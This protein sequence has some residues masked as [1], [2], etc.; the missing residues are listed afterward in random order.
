MRAHGAL[1][2]KALRGRPNLPSRWF[3]LAA[4]V[5]FGTGPRTIA[6]AQRPDIRLVRPMTVADL[7]TMATFGSEPHGY[8]PRDIDVTSPDGRLHAVVVKRGD[9]AHNTNVFALLL[10][11]TDHL[12]DSPAPDTLLMLSSTSNRPAI[13]SLRWLS[14][15]HTLAFL[16]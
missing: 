12:F 4:G 13:G 7:V 15:N 9:V 16:G 8:A 11:R 5:L 1:L 3:T 10:F 14:D 2:H 6:G